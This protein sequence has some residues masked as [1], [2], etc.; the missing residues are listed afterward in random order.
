MTNFQIVFLFIL[1]IC[2]ALFCAIADLVWMVSG[3]REN[4]KENMKAIRR[5]DEKGLDEILY[6]HI[7]FVRR[8]LGITIILGSSC[9]RIFLILFS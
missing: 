1:L 8:F 9:F 6:I 4:A 3:E 5:D 2:L 7:C